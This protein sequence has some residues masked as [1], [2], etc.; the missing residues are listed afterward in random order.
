MGPRQSH[1]GADVVTLEQLSG[2]DAALLALES[3]TT[4][5]QVLGVLILDPTG[6]DSSYS[7]DRLCATVEERIPHMPPFVRELVQV[8]LHLDRPYW[9]P[10]TTIDINAHI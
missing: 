7:F 5:M 9:Q 2:T 1:R 10:V 3:P 6:S 8:P 4:P